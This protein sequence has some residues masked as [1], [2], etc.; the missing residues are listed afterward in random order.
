MP[1]TSVECPSAWRSV[2]FRLSGDAPAAV[3]RLDVAPVNGEKS[4]RGGTAH[5]ALGVDVRIQEFPAKGFECAHGL[6]RRQGKGR[7]PAVNDH[8][9]AATVNGRDHAFDAD[10][11][12]QALGE[13]Q[14]GPAVLE[15][16]RARK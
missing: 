2:D 9:T 12:S 15:E 11:V 6:D 13:R 16:G 10:R 14:I 8:V 4:P 7:L 1:T 5:Q 3:N